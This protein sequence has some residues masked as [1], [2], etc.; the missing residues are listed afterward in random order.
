MATT[1]ETFWISFDLTGFTWVFL[2]ASQAKLDGLLR[3][4][5]IA[6]RDDLVLVFVLIWNLSAGARNSKLNRASSRRHE[7]NDEIDAVW[8]LLRVAAA[9]FQHNRMSKERAWL[10]FVLLWR[11]L[12]YWCV[13]SLP[14]YQTKEASTQW[15]S[16]RR[17]T[18]LKGLQISA[19]RWIDHQMRYRKCLNFVQRINVST[20]L[21]RTTTTTKMCRRG[22]PLCLAR[23]LSISLANWLTK[24][25][26]SSV[27]HLRRHA[28]LVISNLFSFLFTLLGY[29]F[30]LLF[31]YISN[32]SL[33]IFPF[34][35]SLFSNRSRD[36]A[37]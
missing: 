20:F 11:F 29:S 13:V 4:P 34:F 25:V 36:D 18:H 22:R 24:V 5:D 2:L 37:I 12:F 30:C 15:K 1:V 7:R 10:S 16:S 33:A 31:S 8:E 27:F 9:M 28:L 35:F 19:K 3:R 14:S 6:D 32:R 26:S 21:H 23:S 17:L